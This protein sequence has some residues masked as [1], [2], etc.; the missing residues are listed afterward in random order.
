[1]LAWIL[2]FFA[3]GGV[4]GGASETVAFCFPRGIAGKQKLDLE[5]AIPILEM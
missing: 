1:V 2:R 4:L 5:V 3:L